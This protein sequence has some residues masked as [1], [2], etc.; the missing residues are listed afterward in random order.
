MIQALDEPLLLASKATSLKKTPT[1]TTT[2]TPSLF[3]HLTPS[4]ADEVFALNAAFL[5]DPSP[6]SHKTNLGI[7]VYRTESGASWPL[8]SVAA[9]EKRLC[10]RKLSSRHDYLPIQGDVEFLGLA[11]EVVF[12]RQPGVGAAVVGQD[13]VTSV[14]TVSGTGANHL[15]AAFVARYGGAGRVW[16][17]SPT[18]ANHYAI[19][20]MVGVEVR[21][22]PYFHAETKGVDFEGMVKCLEREARR[23]DVVLL[24]ACAHNPTG[25]DPSREEWVKI[26]E[27]C[28]R[29][30]LFPFFD[31]AYQGFASGDLERDA[32][33]VRYFAGLGLEM[34]VAQSFSKN[35]GLYGQRVGALHVVRTDM[36]E[37]VGLALLSSLCHLVRSEFS[38]APR[39]GSDLVK[40][41][42]SDETLRQAWADDLKTMS[43]R[44]RQMR[45]QLYAELCRL[46]TPGD[47]SHIV[48]Q[49]SKGRVHSVFC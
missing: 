45:E 23:G 2:A 22:Y 11:R 46:S 29:R 40:E 1:N 42:L 34:C 8:P 35:F 6:P 24:H 10:E 37:E 14:Q 9:A 15:G 21:E 38:M 20:E 18:W 36:R 3:S 13:S 26:A 19:W 39:N 7:G 31:L 44:I 12:G 32:W 27:V 33:A 17:P 16:L 43:D 25:A 41:I 49:V 48:K 4:P 47:W 28:Q 5:S 30:G